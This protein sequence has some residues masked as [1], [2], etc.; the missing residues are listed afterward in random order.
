[1]DSIVTV[2]FW[3]SKNPALGIDLWDKVPCWG[4][5]FSTPTLF[6]SPQGFPWF[7]VILLTLDS[8]LYFESSAVLALPFLFFSHCLFPLDATQILS[9]HYYSIHNECQSNVNLRIWKLR[10]LHYGVWDEA[11]IQ[12]TFD[13]WQKRK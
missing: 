6:F 4:V 13:F 12:I 2:R 3:K 9:Q 1:M 10:F 7:K 11:K 8:T 5:F